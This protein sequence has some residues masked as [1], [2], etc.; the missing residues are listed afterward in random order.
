MLATGTIA[1]NNITVTGKVVDLNSKSGL[2]YVNIATL[3]DDNHLGTTDAEG[4][5][6]ITAPQGTTILFT[7]AGYDSYK[8]AIKTTGPLLI[9]L[10]PK[11]GGKDD[12]V[13]VQAFSERNRDLKTGASTRVSGDVVKNVPAS[14]FVDLLQGRAAGLNIQN[15]AGSPGAVGTITIRGTSQIGVSSDGF[16]TPSSPLFIIDGVPVDI[17]SNYSYNNNTTANNVNPLSLIPPDDI[18][19]FDILKDAAAMSLYGSRAANGVIIVTTKRGRSRIPQVNYRADFFV[20]RPPRL[21][22]TIG[23]VEERNMR[24]NTILAYDTTRLETLKALVNQS[25][26]LADSLNPYFNNSTN[27]QD[28]YYRPSANQ[29]HNIQISGGDMKFN[30][31]TNLNY[32]SEKGIVKNTDFERYT[33]NMQAGYNPNPKFRMLAT[34]TA[35][36]G[37]RGNGTSVDGLQSGIA[38]SAATSSLLP[39]PTLYD[40]N[41]AAAGPDTK[42]NQNR[43]NSI[44]GNLDV[45]YTFIDGLT[46]QNAFS[47]NYNTNNNNLFIPSALSGSAADVR[48]LDDRNYTINNRSV[49]KYNKEAGKHSFA[50]FVFS[51]LNAFGSKY[52]NVRLAGTAN[53]QIKGPLGY[54]W[55]SSQGAI[56]SLDGNGNVVNPVK[57]TRMIGYGGSMFYSFD[58]KYIFS[59]DY[60]V[61]LSSSN[62]PT[63]GWVHSPSVSGRWNFFREKWF[64]DAAW[65]SEGAI[66]GSWGQVTTPVGD[67]FNVYGK[68]I[69][70]APY[71]NNPTVTLDFNSIPN[72]DFSPQVVTYLNGGLDIG[73]F[74]NNV[75]VTL[76]A[77]YK[78]TENQLTDIQLNNTTAFGKY[79]LNGASVVNRGFEF[80]GDFVILNRED[81][82]IFLNTNF[83]IDK[84]TLVKLPGGLR[85]RT[86]SITDG[87]M[88]LPVLQRIGL[89][90]F[91][92]IMLINKGV[93]ASTDDV[94]VDPNTGLRL[95]Y[96]RNNNMFF[97]AGDPIWVDINGDYVIDDNDLVPVGNPIPLINGGFN[98][99][100]TYKDFVL[101]FSIAFTL[102]RDIINQVL[103]SRMAAYTSPYALNARQSI[104]DYN[105][106]KPNN[107]DL[108]NGTVGAVYPNP[109]DYVRSNSLGTFR[110]NQ[111]LYL[112][113]GSYVKM[114]SIS[115]M[116]NIN[117]KLISR[118]G[119]TQFQLRASMRNVFTITN[120]SGVNP[121]SVTSLGRD[122]SGG[123]PNAKSYSLGIGIIF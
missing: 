5:F 92:N 93:Y 81:L 74:S 54:E 68:Y 49:L 48:F 35:G 9:E 42:N 95:Q 31:K 77:Y 10:S 114:N 83:A 66:R 76:D 8:M 62:G 86:Q 30:Y 59:V 112:E 41:S 60:R 58:K 103:A 14:S 4:A 117:R 22:P 7:Y 56:G 25:F 108:D 1:Q 26:F 21:L 110:P 17:N 67:I 79:V 115:L 97:K 23:G 2:A 119:L 50:P 122:V 116:Y 105:Y 89:S 27:W 36:Y 55:G 111:T 107:G 38:S 15:N 84:S 75:R 13:I 90:Q 113:D 47:Y 78:T 120:Y 11:Q 123:Y 51:E 96:G 118:Y 109:Y 28:V 19:S 3:K 44:S 6:T 34:I 72:V 16:L 57:E 46:A 100:L 18:E 52:Y 80:T 24:I 71:N 32:Y 20:N 64:E 39:P 102:K 61:D 101:N 65:L 94:P 40:V 73:L 69:V 53:D 70:G 29:T 33:L 37:V 87:T 85:E 43:A 106:W 82:R 91:T 98:P 45:Q 104:S 88:S 63:R 12:E 99:S 121:E